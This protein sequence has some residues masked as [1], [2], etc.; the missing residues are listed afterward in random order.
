MPY[1]A[2]LGLLVHSQ[3]LCRD[4][5]PGLSCNRGCC[6]CLGRG[7]NVYSAERKIGGGGLGSYPFDSGM[8]ERIHRG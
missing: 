2:Y 4:F 3:S 1:H 8:S 6:L 7:G 5:C